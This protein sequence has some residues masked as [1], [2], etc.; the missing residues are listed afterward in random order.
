HAQS[1]HLHP[2]TAVHFGTR[3]RGQRV[4][5]PRLAHG[6]AG[7]AAND[8]IAIADEA[9]LVHLERDGGYVGV[10]DLVVGALLGDATRETT[11]ITRTGRAVAFHRHEVHEVEHRAEID[12]E[13]FLALAHEHAA[14]LAAARDVHRV[15]ERVRVGLVLRNAA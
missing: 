9:V 7:P 11:A 12:R 4:Q 13:A 1:R 2:R 6:S 10:V 5:Q 15:D 14:R 3:E 8:A